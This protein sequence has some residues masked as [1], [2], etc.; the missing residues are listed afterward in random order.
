MKKYIILLFVFTSL[1]AHSQF[2]GR[3]QRQRQTSQIPQ[4]APEPDFK[5]DKY[6]GIIIYDIKK[7]AKKSSIKLS[8]EEG[9]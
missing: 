6:L 9:K 3:N 5:I 8:S 7:A 2:G 4:Q 1:L